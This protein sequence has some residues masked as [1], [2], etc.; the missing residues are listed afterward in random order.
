MILL[1]NVRIPS[2]SVGSISPKYLRNTHGS[3]LFWWCN[4]FVLCSS[5][6][7]R[8]VW[9]LRETRTGLW[10]MNW[11]LYGQA[12]QL[13]AN[14]S[15]IVIITASSQ[16]VSEIPLIHWQFILDLCRVLRSTGA[17]LNSILDSFTWSQMYLWIYQCK[18]S[19]WTCVWWDWWL[20]ASALSI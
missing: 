19:S 8:P 9:E 7:R 17:C 15:P 20:N 5:K 1:W 6:V 3:V 13:H 11:Y 18:S 10:L 2:T 16:Q 4:F 14:Y 12:L